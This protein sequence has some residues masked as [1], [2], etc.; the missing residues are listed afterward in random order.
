MNKPIAVLDSGVGGFTVVKDLM[1]L[2]PFEEIVYYGDTARAPYGDRDKEEVQQFTAEILHYLLRFEPKIVVIAC[3]TATAYALEHVQKMVSIPVIGVIKPGAIAAL[4]ATKLGCIGVIG[5]TGTINSKAYEQALYTLNPD[6]IIIS[7]ACPQL[8]PLVEQGD[9]SSEAAYQNVLTA[10]KELKD[11]KLDCLILG[12]THYPFLNK[13][14]QKAIG[15]QVSL[16][17]SGYETAKQVK[18]HLRERK[19]L[20]DRYGDYM[21][22]SHTFICSGELS[23]FQKIGREWLAAELYGQSSNWKSLMKEKLIQR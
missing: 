13:L 1:R 4:Q 12:C 21:T 14:L 20:S 6:I 16:I 23:M 22:V 10:V 7:K 8:V 9:F 18:E 17:H 19:L 2:L 15:E 11:N 5:T 3:N